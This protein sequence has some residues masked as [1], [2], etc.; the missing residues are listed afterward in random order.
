[1]LKRIAVIVTLIAPI[2]AG[3]QTFQPGRVA[4]AS[5]DSF[6]VVYQGQP[7]GS[8]IMAHNKAADNIT[9][10]T[11]VRLPMMGVT[12]VDSLVFNATTLAPV[13]ITTSQSMQGRT[14]A[15][16]I[17]VSNGKA[18]GS[19]QQP[20][21]AGMQT[22]PID[23]AVPAGVIADG[24]E[25]VMIPTIDFSDGLTMN[26]QTF[27]GKAGKTK[28]YVLKVLGKE[29]VTVPAGTFEAWKA[30]INGDGELVQIWVS[31]AEPRKVLQLRLEAQQIEMKRASK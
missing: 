22:M 20:G 30:E 13:L 21:P 15:G 14:A 1:M 10:V 29:S 25:S 2:S 6:E 16:R 26:F 24:A 8:F 5:R 7:I 23:V 17:T 4:A 18:T 9:L 31:T 12:G 28:S 11:E 19:M 3:A 27:D